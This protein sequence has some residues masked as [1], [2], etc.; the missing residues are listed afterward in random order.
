MRTIATS[1]LAAI[2]LSGIAHAAAPNMKEGLWEITVRMEMPGMPGGMPP[3]VMQQCF[4]RKDLEDPRRT[5]PSGGPGDSNCQMTDYKMQGNTAT[6]N[7][8]CKGEGAMTGSGSITYS[9]TSYAGTN[10]MTMTEGGSG[11]TMTMHYSGRHL[12]ACRKP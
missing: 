12:G 6:W 9:G 11:Q 8:A 5:V 2:V 1:L 4:T 10:R 3:Q 7:M